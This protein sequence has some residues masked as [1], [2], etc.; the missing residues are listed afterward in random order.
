VACGVIPKLM[1]ASAPPT[2]PVTGGAASSLMAA[3]AGVLGF[4]ALSAGLLL[5]Q[6]SQPRRRF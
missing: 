1:S 3:G 2:L 5:R 6:R 4:C